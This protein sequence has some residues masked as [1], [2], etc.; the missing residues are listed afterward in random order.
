MTIANFL[1][2]HPETGKGV[3][4]ALPSWG[5][6]AAEAAAGT[7]ESKKGMVKTLKENPP[8]Q[9]KTMEP[10]KSALVRCSR[11]LSDPGSAWAVRPKRGHRRFQPFALVGHVD[12]VHPRTVDAPGHHSPAPIAEERQALPE[13]AAAQA[14]AET[15]PNTISGPRT[16]AGTPRL[17]VR[18]TET[19]ELEPVV[20]AAPLGV[21]ER[22][23]QVLPRLGHNKKMMQLHNKVQQ[24]NKEQG[25]MCHSHWT[26]RGVGQQRAEHDHN[27]WSE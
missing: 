24:S 1:A 22:N 9:W 11:R 17:W 13:P 19:L 4:E 14:Q 21:V 12:R 26:P 7:A 25:G 20:P 10:R 27:T 2:K 15:Q 23:R 16:R 8:T 18:G 6:T 5:L 3:Q